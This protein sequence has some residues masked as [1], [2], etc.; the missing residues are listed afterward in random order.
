VTGFD[1]RGVGGL[2]GTASALGSMGFEKSLM[3]ALIGR[4]GWM[5]LRLYLVPLT[6][7]NFLILWSYQIRQKSFLGARLYSDMSRSYSFA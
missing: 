6:I 2:Y 4:P 1:F 5:I 3:L 7:R